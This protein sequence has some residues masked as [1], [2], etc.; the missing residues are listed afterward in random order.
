MAPESTFS[1]A[2]ECMN[3]Q[4][5][6]THR[7]ISDTLG[8]ERCKLCSAILYRCTKDLKT[9]IEEGRVYRID[10][11]LFQYLFGHMQSSDGLAFPPPDLFD[12]LEADTIVQ[13]LLSQHFIESRS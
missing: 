2:R 11:S 6:E 3:A 13:P 7:K 4:T 8:S 10:I 9:A 5:L 1:M 12:S